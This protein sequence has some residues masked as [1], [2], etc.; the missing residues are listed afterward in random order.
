MNKNTLFFIF[1]CSL[2]VWANDASVPTI[3]GLR[4]K[5]GPLRVV[6][7]V[8]VGTFAVQFSGF[9]QRE[10][11][12]L[13][14]ANYEIPLKKEDGEFSV[15]V[16]V[17]I[18]RFK[19]EFSARDEQGNIERETAHV[20]LKGFFP[21]ENQQRMPANWLERES[22]NLSMNVGFGPTYLF[23]QQTDLHAV[24]ETNLSSR[25]DFTYVIDPGVWLFEASAFASLVSLNYS[26]LAEPGMQTLA[27]DLRLG[28]E[29]PFQ[30]GTWAAF[31]FGGVYG[32][33]TY[34]TENVGY[35]GIYGPEFF[36]AVRYHFSNGSLL[37]FFAKYSPVMNGIRFLD[38][39]N[40]H[41]S[42][43]TTYY[44]RPFAQGMLKGVP[45]GIN[46]EASRLK[47]AVSRGEILVMSYT[48]GLNLMF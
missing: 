46:F 45:L 38:F 37:G 3:T 32:L 39:G 44:F 34:G 16:P 8:S 13:F 25:L 12:R 41:L 40:S 24:S 48:A 30:E 22:R 28:Y 11:W 42:I 4:W 36:P 17:N 2:G 29:F 26:P 18:N 7:N 43:G 20:F 47:L 14:L 21:E 1:L 10:G 27:G 15:F 23:Y 19:V 33:G 5:F 9:Y 6:R 35:G 31:L